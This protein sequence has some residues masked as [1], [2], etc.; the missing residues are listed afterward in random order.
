MVIFREKP[1]GLKTNKT[2]LILGQLPKTILFCA[3]GE[4]AKPRK[5]MK[6]GC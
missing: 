5:I 3:L 6:N 2:S 1:N 4:G